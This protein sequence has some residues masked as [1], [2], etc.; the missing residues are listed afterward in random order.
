MRFC[1]CPRFALCRAISRWA[2]D[3]Q[4]CAFETIWL[5]YTL[6]CEGCT[7]LAPPKNRCA[8]KFRW[9]SIPISGSTQNLKRHSATTQSA[10]FAKWKIQNSCNSYVPET[11]GWP[12]PTRRIAQETACQNTTKSQA[13]RS[14][15]LSIAFGH[16]FR[17]CAEHLS[18]FFLTMRPALRFHKL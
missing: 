4:C 2:L 8:I 12:R 14:Y 17:H 6:R 16:P 11:V 3:E 13:S 18:L 15:F 1:H 9:P 7:M 10:C 5:I